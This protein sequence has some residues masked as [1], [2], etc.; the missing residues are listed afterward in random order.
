VL[1]TD[2][3]Q[4]Q[5]G[6]WTVAI[7]HTTFCIVVIFNNVVARLRRTG[8]SFEEASMDLGASTFQTFRL[9][10]FPQ[11]R[12]ALVAAALL[13]FG[14][15]FDEVIVT[16]LTTANG[17]E[18]LPIWIF[19][20]LSRPNN[21]PI[22]NVVAAFVILISIIPVYFAQRLSDDPSHTRL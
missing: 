20:N 22:V 8:Q 13:A 18:T 21:A 6:F 9:V 5:L 1:S 14:L 2:G 15:S 4:I 3:F 17:F 16:Q 11:I 19:N 12:S 7:G 10:T